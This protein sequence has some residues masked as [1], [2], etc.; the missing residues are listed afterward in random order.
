MMGLRLAD[1]VDPARYERLA[2]QALS[3]SRIADLQNMGLVTAT[4]EAI[5]VTNQGFTLL[6]GVLRTLLED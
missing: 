3:G 2:G 1:G 5:S 6:N 4:K